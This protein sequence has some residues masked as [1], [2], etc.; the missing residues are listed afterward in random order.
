MGFETQ[1]MLMWTPLLL[2]IEPGNMAQVLCLFVEEFRLSLWW[3]L[4][5]CADPPEN[6]DRANEL[7]SLNHEVIEVEVAARET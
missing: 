7:N 5:S 2:V 1:A 6:G 4:L 3:T